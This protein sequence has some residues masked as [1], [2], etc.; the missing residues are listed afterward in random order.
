MAK[1][2]F[3]ESLNR[4]VRAGGWSDQKVSTF[5]EVH[6]AIDERQWS[7]AADLARYFVE[8]AEV[9]WKLYRQWTGALES[10]LLDHG[11]SN[12]DLDSLRSH[13]ADVTRLPDGSAFVPE[14]EWESLHG[15]TAQ[16]VQACE[17]ADGE[18]AHHLM[19]Q[20]RETWR[21]THDRDVDRIY[22]YTSEVSTRLG[23]DAIL[24]M[25]QTILGP[26]FESRYQMFDID[27]FKW[28]ESLDVLMYVTF[29]AMRGHLVGPERTGDIGF[30]E[31][32]DRYVLSFDPCGSGGR[33]VQGD[34]IEGTGP[35]M[36]APY[37]WKVSEEPHDWNHFTP[38]VCLYCA[39]C[40]VLTEQM[41]MDRFG[42]PVRVIDPPVYTEGN[43]ERQQCR[44]TMYKDPT[45][46]PEEV[47]ERA[48]R[49]KP[50]SFGSAAN[51][52]EQVFI[53]TIQVPVKE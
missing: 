25:W 33:T 1:L 44:W 21:R 38:G 18:S 53:G 35:R 5:S 42:Y 31:F 37:N 19:D 6:R 29:E 24:D 34:E 4:K 9:C 48:G 10:Y 3:S 22:G 14:V 41:P 23:E 52:G 20:A 50:K 51:G 2:T 27:T 43:V 11:V 28:D 13:L 40:I 32:D 17:K 36:E 45:L 7:D 12:E 39:H 16:V 26:W 46:V 15:L 47:Y 30:E 8:E 49:T